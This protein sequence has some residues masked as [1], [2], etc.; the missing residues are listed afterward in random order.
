MGMACGRVSADLRSEAPATAYNIHTSLS[1]LPGWL[2]G[3]SDR[4]VPQVS[5]Q[6]AETEPTYLTV[7][8]RRERDEREQYMGFDGSRGTAYGKA[9]SDGVLLTRGSVRGAPLTNGIRDKRE[10]R[11]GIVGQDV[12]ERWCLNTAYSLRDD[13]YPSGFLDEYPNA[14]L[15]LPAQYGHY[16]RLT[17]YSL[18]LETDS[19]EEISQ[20]LPAADDGL[21]RHPATP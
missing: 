4:T 1:H 17:A 14:L 2:V 11:N 9:Y 13:R 19:S 18:L 21:R 5:T 20:P 8:F 3:F 10:S 15:E 6:I 16:K 12:I 7:V